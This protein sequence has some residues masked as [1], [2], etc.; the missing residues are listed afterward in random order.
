MVVVVT[1]HLDRD[2]GCCCHQL[3]WRVFA[4]RRLGKSI[5][6]SLP[7]GSIIIQARPATLNSDELLVWFEFIG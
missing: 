5:P 2:L 4:E 6:C 7:R 3:P 1:A